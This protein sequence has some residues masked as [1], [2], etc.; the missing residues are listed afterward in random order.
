MPS[1]FSPN[2]AREKQYRN[3]KRIQIVFSQGDA[4]DA[5]FYVQKGKIKLTV[6]SDR[7]KGQSLASSG[8][9]VFLAKDFS[10]FI[11][12][13]PPQPRRL[14]NVSLRASTRRQ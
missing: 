12:S 7:A 4:A 8:S 5:L 3:F 2:L 14:T 6:V 11:L 10:M 13:V 9:V 1:S